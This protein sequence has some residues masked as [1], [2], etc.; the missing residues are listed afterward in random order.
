MNSSYRMFFELQREPFTADIAHKEILVTP[1]IKGVEERI[2]YAVRL[3]AVALI[4]G[5]I[6]SGKSTALRYVAGSFHPSE[7]RILHVTASAGSILKSSR[8]SKM[9]SLAKK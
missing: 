4:T 7:Y 5:E 6:G 2:R 3:G 1:A 9:P 8:K